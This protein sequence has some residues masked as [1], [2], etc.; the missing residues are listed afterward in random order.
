MAGYS[1]AVVE[2][3]SIFVSGTL[4]VDFTTMQ[5]PETAAAQ[6][7]L[8]FAGAANT[9]IC[10]PLAVEEAKVEIEV[11]AVKRAS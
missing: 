3:D 8:A 1:R 6:A 7:E 2:G 4:G 9:T 5:I 11:T 10:S